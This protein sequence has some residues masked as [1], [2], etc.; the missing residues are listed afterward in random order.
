MRTNL[1]ARSQAQFVSGGRKRILRVLLNLCSNAI[2]YSGETS[3][4]STVLVIVDG[5]EGGDDD[6]KMAV[7]FEVADEGKGM[8][9]EEQVCVCAF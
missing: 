8:S 3:R 1:D 5:V 6:T 9:K 7:R 4:A 2:K